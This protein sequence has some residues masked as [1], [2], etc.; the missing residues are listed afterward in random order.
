MKT[1]V[2]ALVLAMGAAGVAQADVL[3]LDAIREA[4]P[5]SSSGVM[6]PRGGARMAQVERD[7]GAPQAIKN[8]V[9]DPPI[10]RWIYPGYTVY[11]EYDAVIDVVVHRQ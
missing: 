8:A 4:P 1:I 10:A 5:N 2:P 3:L 6:R 7:F 11:F 9:G